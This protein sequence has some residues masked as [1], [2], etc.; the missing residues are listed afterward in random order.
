MMEQVILKKV[1]ALAPLIE[2]KRFLLVHGSSYDALGVR[3]FFDN[4]FHAEFS[5]F[6]PNPLYEQVSLG[7][8]KFRDEKCEMIIAV[9]G[10]SA[11]DVAKCIKLY[12]N[13]NQ[14]K[15]FLDQEIDQNKIPLIAIPTTRGSGSEATRYAVIFYEGEKQSVTHDSIIPDIVVQQSGLLKSLHIWKMC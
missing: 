12:A 11:I 3:D 8:K 6:H 1:E 9:G 4:Y 2:K 7:V 14:E 10:G 5:G 15:C 13:L